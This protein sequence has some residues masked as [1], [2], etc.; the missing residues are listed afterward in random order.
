MKKER[1]LHISHAFQRDW[2]TNRAH[3]YKRLLQD[4]QPQSEVCQSRH[5]PTFCPRCYPYRSL[6]AAPHQEIHAGDVEYYPQ[7][8]GKKW[9][10]MKPAIKRVQ[11]KNLF[12]L[13]R[14]WA[15]SAKPKYKYLKKFTDHVG[16]IHLLS[17]GFVWERGHP[18]RI[19]PCEARQIVYL[20][21]N[22]SPLPSLNQFFY[23]FCW[24]NIR[25]SN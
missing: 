7:Q 12:L 10:M 20:I 14:A 22:Y 5:T 23:L 8:A 4:I 1:Q 9:R 13:C 25:I 24:L 11:R 3:D 17:M 16:S 15:G 21:E 19:I 2:A 18:D 6:S